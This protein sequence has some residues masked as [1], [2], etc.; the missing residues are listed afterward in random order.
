M[1]TSTARFWPPTRS[2]CVRWRQ[3]IISWHSNAEDI[4]LQLGS[5]EQVIEAF[6][7]GGEIGLSGGESLDPKRN[8]QPERPPENKLPKR[9]SKIPQPRPA[10][11]EVEADDSIDADADID[12]VEAE[13]MGA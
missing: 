3:E 5:L 1:T 6:G 11:R 13:L 7:I 12:L 8:P 4:N 9:R 2:L 10:S